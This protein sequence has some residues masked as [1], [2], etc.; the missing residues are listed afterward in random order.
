MTWMP[1]QGR[2]GEDGKGKGG[3]RARVHAGGDGELPGREDSMDQGQLGYFGKGRSGGFKGKGGGKGARMAT[4]ARQAIGT[5]TRYIQ[6]AMQLV[7]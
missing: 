2:E 7:R 3:R 5:S 6:D 1:A 4:R